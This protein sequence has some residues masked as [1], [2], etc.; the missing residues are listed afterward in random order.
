MIDALELAGRA[1]LVNEVTAERWRFSHAIVRETLLDELSSSRRV[2]QHRKV[3]AAI[4]TR[5][6]SDLDVVANQL[7]Y[8]WGEA[9]AGGVDLPKALEWGIRAGDLAFAKSAVEDAIRWYEHS[10]GLLDPDDPS[11]AE[12][13]AVLVRLARAKALTG[14]EY[15]DTMLEAAALAY[16]LGDHEQLTAALVVTGRS[17]YSQDAGLATPELIEHW[18]GPSP[19]SDPMSP[20]S[21][22]SSS[23]RWRSSFNSSARENGAP[24]CAS[25]RTSWPWHRPTTTPCSPRSLRT[26]IR[27]R[28]R[29]SDE[30]LTAEVVDALAALID[31]LVVAGDG[32]R[33]AIGLH[34]L[35][36]AARWA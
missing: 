9:A 26:S 36:Y 25:N 35:W 4:E 11:P 34:M 29:R 2:R 20:A 32:Y 30:R 7:A 24:P 12:Q 31:K 8:H 23:P 10:L 13:C 21:E 28:Y 1:A 17:G 18:S 33:I 14:D 15:H 3:A 22:R 5:A 27:I 19:S 16:T 6:S